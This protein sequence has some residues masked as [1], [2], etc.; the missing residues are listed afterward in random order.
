MKGMM[1]L[2]IS[3]PGSVIEATSDVTQ[4]VLNT[5]TPTCED[6]QK[7]PTT[8]PCLDCKK[9][10]ILRFFFSLDEVYATSK[11]SAVAPARTTADHSPVLS[12]RWRM[13]SRTWLATCTVS[14][15]CQRLLN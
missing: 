12:G 2:C 6:T 5:P 15:N 8:M 3:N 13:L 4:L 7:N 11:A 10:Q 1:D 14:R 9:K